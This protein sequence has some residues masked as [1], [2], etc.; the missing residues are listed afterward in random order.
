MRLCL[1]LCKGE[2]HAVSRKQKTFGDQGCYI[3][4]C[5]C[6]PGF[7]RNLPAYWE[8]ENGGGLYDRQ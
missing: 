2:K 7:P 8:S 4:R 6:L 5:H 3:P 1:K